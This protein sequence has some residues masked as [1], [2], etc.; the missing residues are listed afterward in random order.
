MAAFDLDNYET[1][2]RKD[3]LAELQA[4]LQDFL[5][6]H[7]QAHH[8]LVPSYLSILKQLKAQP[9]EFLKQAPRVMADIKLVQEGFG[10]PFMIIIFPCAK[11]LSKVICLQEIRAMEDRELLDVRACLIQAASNIEKVG[12]EAGLLTELNKKLLEMSFT[13]KQLLAPHFGT[14][15]KLPVGSCYRMLA[16]LCRTKVWSSADVRSMLDLLNKLQEV[17]QAQRNEMKQKK[18]KAKAKVTALIS[19]PILRTLL[20]LDDKPTVP[21]PPAP[22]QQ[23][24]QQEEEIE[25]V[26]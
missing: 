3:S 15:E 1:Q 16:K 20:G 21:A 24:D 22:E 5:Q 11:Q 10:N 26:P 13:R 12:V 14:A 4:V 17:T 25:E 2:L 23:E 7:G 6:K 19:D 18:E 8:H 9:D